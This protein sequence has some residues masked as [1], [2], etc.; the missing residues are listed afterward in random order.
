[1]NSSGSKRYYLPLLLFALVC[2]IGVGA[3]VVAYISPGSSASSPA[4]LTQAQAN[5]ILGTN[6][7]TNTTN[8]SGTLASMNSSTENNKYS[9][10]M[11]SLADVAAV[12]SPAVVRIDTVKVVEKS[13]TINQGTGSIYD[14]FNN[15]FG[16][17]FGQSF[18]EAGTGSGFIVSKEGHIVTN[19]HVIDGADSIKVTLTDGRSF[20]AK[21]VGSHEDS[22]VAIIKIESDEDFPVAKIGDS[23][24]LRPG[25]WVLAIGNPYGFEHTVTAGIVSALERDVSDSKGQSITTGELIQTDAAINQGNSGGPLIDMNGNV[26]GINTAIIPYAQGIGFAISIDSVKDVLNQL[27]VNG[28]VVKPWIG[29]SIQGITNDLAS[30]MGLPTNDGILVSDVVKDSPAAK[31]GLQRGD[32]IKEMNGVEVTS[33]TDLPGEVSKMDIGDNVVFWIWRGNQKMYVTVTLGETS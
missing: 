1:M 30:A 32:V 4:N 22:D 24:S 19:H 5:E 15:F 18:E 25:D 33:K 7:G 29:I 16:Y 8:P 14:L 26:V 17:D 23:S 27:M 2:C 3:F 20:D 12:V 6:G 13:P 21:L 11:P 10:V 31:A 28:K 9:M